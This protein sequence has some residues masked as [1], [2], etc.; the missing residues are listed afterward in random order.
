MANLGNLL[1]WGIE[2]STP[3]SEAKTEL[4]PALLAQL[5]SNQKSDATLMKEAMEAIQDPE[6]SLKDKETA[7]DNF[8]LMIEQLDNANNIEN[9]EL[10]PPLISLLSAPEKEL[11]LL[12]AWCCGTAVQNNIKSQQDFHKHGGVSKLVDL[13]LKDP[14]EDVRKKAVYA[15]SS[16]VRNLQPALDAGLESLPSELLAGQELKADNMEGIDALMTKLRER[17]AN[18]TE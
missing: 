4:N 5:F 8:E 12:A 2:N 1:A 3:R 15:L 7:F 17:A 11:R 10:W 13:L 9:L 16:A 14:A 6:V 18:I